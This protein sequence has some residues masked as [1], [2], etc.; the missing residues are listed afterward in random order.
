MS[1]VAVVGALVLV[2]GNA[3]ANDGDKKSNRN[4]TTVNANY[5]HQMPVSQGNTFKSNFGKVEKESVNRNYKQQ[6]QEKRNVKFKDHFGKPEKT[7]RSS[8]KHP[9]GL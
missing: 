5:K 8:Y 7:N 2:S 6:N 1:L 3:M 4:A 9:N